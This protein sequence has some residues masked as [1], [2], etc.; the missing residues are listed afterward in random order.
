[1]FGSELLVAGGKRPR[2]GGLNETARPLGV[3]L[4]IH[5]SSLS[6]PWTRV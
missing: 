1:M 4:E 6:R 3:L 2:L 5:A